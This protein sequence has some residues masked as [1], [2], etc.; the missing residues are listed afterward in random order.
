MREGL[1]APE[2]FGQGEQLF[3]FAAFGTRG[4]FCCFALFGL[5]LEAFLEQLAGVLAVFIG[6]IA[7]GAAVEIQTLCAFSISFR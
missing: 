1:F 7:G 5:F 6:D 4:L 3:L 2:F